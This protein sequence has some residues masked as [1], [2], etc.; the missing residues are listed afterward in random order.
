MADQVAC[1][2]G[3][4]L[5]VPTDGLRF[6]CPGCG[7]VYDVQN[8]GWYGPMEAPAT[9][10]DWK[11]EPMDVPVKRYPVDW[12]YSAQDVARIRWGLRPRAQEEKW[13][14]Y[15]EGDS[16]FIFR[17]WSGAFCYKATFGGQGVCRVEIREDM[18]THDGQLKMVRFLLEAKM[19]GRDISPP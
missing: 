4:T 3:Q 16:M 6:R 1:R 13:F 11:C 10:S 17:S 2:S 19:I 8:I 9:A 5:A 12:P 15:A 18:P 7:K 14:A